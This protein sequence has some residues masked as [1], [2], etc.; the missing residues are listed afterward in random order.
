MLNSTT[1]TYHIIKYVQAVC[2]RL[3]ADGRVTLPCSMKTSCCGWQALIVTCATST[4]PSHFCGEKWTK[5]KRSWYRYL[6]SK[7]THDFRMGE[8]DPLLYLICRIRH[9]RHA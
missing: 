6:G 7:A 5:H 2:P 3:D 9:S 1:M 4:Y 8:V